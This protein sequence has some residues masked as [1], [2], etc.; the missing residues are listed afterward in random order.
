MSIINEIFSSG[1]DLYKFLAQKSKSGNIT[2]KLIFRE[3]RNNIQ[4]LEHRNKPGIDRIA[5]IGKLEGANIYAAIKEGFDFNRLAPKQVVDNNLIKTA[6]WAQK[7]KG[8]DADQLILSIDEKITA[9]KDITG[10]Y[11]DVG[12]A[13]LNITRRLNNLFLLC[14]LLVLLIKRAGE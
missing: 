8:W 7:Y 1:F 4:R 3:L 2:R 6:T 12:N 14:I 10:I 9:L 5:L 13:P 11:S